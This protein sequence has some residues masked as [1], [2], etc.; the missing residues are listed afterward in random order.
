MKVYLLVGLVLFSLL[1][2]GFVSPSSSEFRNCE[3][4]C[5]RRCDD[6]SSASCLYHCLDDCEFDE[7]NR[8]LKEKES[9]RDGVKLILLIVGIWVVV[10][11]CKRKKKKVK[12]G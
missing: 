4:K 7:D 6:S 8:V 11:L 12:N 2:V 9:E 1:S 5:D 3:N 10:V